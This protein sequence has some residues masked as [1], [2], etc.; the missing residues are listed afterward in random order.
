VAHFRLKQY[1]EAV[2]DYSEFIKL[3]PTRADVWCD[4]GNAYRELQQYGKASADFSEAIKLDAKHA[5]AWYGRGMIHALL[6]QPEQAIPD[7]SETIKLNEKYLP[8][9]MNRA[10]AH[11]ELHQYEQAIA[12]YKEAI[13]LDDREAHAYGGL[14]QLLATAADPKYRD[15]VQALEMAKKGTELAPRVASHWSV[16]GIAHVRA[17]EGQAAVTA[18][19]RAMKLSNGGDAF[20]WFILALA[21]WQ[22]GNKQEARRWYDRGVAWMEN[23]KEALARDKYQADVIRGVGDEAAALLEMKKRHD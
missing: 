3:N 6:H 19:D 18:L 17:G 13:R 12:D 20:D 2:A 1:Q 8:A 10:G 9:W 15:P 16:L 11:C 14:A 4:R 22:L 7:L 23:N 5:P 21:H